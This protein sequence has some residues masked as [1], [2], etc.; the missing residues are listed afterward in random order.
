MALNNF[1]FKRMLSKIQFKEKMIKGLSFLESKENYVVSSGDANIIYNK[2]QGDELLEILVQNHHQDVYLKNGEYYRPN[3]F[4]T[5][6]IYKHFPEVE[7]IY[8]IICAGENFSGESFT[9]RY[10]L[11]EFLYSALST[12]NPDGRQDLQIET[13]ENLE[14]LCQTIEQRYYSTE[15]QMFL[16]LTLEQINSQLQ[17][18]IKTKTM[19]DLI[20]GYGGCEPRLFIIGFMLE[21]EFVIDFFKNEYMPQIQEEAKTEFY[22]RK[23]ILINNRI[24]NYFKK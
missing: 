21:N 22:Y 23:F 13:E 10:S 19:K 9:I 15:V 2:H 5:V 3:S 20:Y 4:S 14:L 12:L 1:K 8:Q 18:L 17:Q 24:L 11:R 6:E 7:K 16:S